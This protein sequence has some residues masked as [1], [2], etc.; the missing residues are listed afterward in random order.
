L[1]VFVL[2]VSSG[3]FVYAYLHTSSSYII[4]PVVPREGQHEIFIGPPIILGEQQNNSFTACIVH[5]GEGYFIL[6]HS[7]FSDPMRGLC[8]S[9]SYSIVF[10]VLIVVS[11][12]DFFC[13]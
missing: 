7:N 6:L 1:P 8:P 11:V 12:T 4:P 13:A 10:V 3:V 2:E 9:I 5:R